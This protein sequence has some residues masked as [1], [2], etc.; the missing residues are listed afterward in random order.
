MGLECFQ[1]S[2]VVCV[3]VGI[4][5]FGKS[6]I[7]CIGCQKGRAGALVIITLASQPTRAAGPWYV[8]P[9]G[10]DGNSCLSPGAACATINGALGKADPGDTIYVATG[11]YTGTGDEVVLL[12]KDATLSE[13]GGHLSS[14]VHW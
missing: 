10:D 8:A 14:M 5:P 2:V 9:C 7:I 11:T 6:T 13:G 4:A 1:K 12:D 3:V